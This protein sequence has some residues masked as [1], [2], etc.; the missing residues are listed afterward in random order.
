MVKLILAETQSGRPVTIRLQE[1]RNAYTSLWASGAT[2]WATPTTVI[3]EEVETDR[4][5]KPIIQKAYNAYVSPDLD[6]PALMEGWTAN[7]EGV[8]MFRDLGHVRWF[9]E[10]YMRD[11]IVLE[12]E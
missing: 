2:V 10:V 12:V 1:P 3:R 6:N 5:G 8:G 4:N 9:Y 11:P 7:L